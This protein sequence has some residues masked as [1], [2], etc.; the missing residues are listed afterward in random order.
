MV[1]LSNTTVSCG[2]VAPPQCYTGLTAR[3][4]NL[5][6]TP[7]GAPRHR[8]FLRNPTIE[9]HKIVIHYF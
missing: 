4:Y 1:L 5:V 6:R 8:F 3:T 9:A 2:V 7:R